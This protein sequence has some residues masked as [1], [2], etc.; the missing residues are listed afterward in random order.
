M[1]SLLI[2]NTYSVE[3]IGYTAR[4]VSHNNTAKLMPFAIQNALIL[5]A[6]VLFSA[7]IYMTL[8]RVIRSVGGENYSVFKPRWLTSI[9]VTG[10]ILALSIQ[11]G[12]A[13][14]MVVSSLA[15]LGEGIVVGGLAFH[16]VIFGVFWATATI[17]QVKMRRAVAEHSLPH[18]SKW[19]QILYML[20]SSSA[21][22][23]GRSI[24]R[25]IEFIMGHDGYL[26]S[27][28][29]PLYVFDSV[30]MVIVMVIFCWRF[31]SALQQVKANNAWTEMGRQGESTSNLSRLEAQAKS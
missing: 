3:V 1:I 15:S 2:L 8:S 6:P 19:Q 21:L 17:F 24:F 29:W 31:P 12:A 18:N 10:D 13:G 9:F 20:Y 28:E 22:I 14:M 30:P 25:M 4:I 11:S 26:L 5:L 7:S 16:I 27:T 23:M